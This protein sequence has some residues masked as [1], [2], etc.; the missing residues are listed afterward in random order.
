L[1]PETE[2]RLRD[3]AAQSGQSWKAFLLALIEREAG[4]A[5]GTTPA[6]SPTFE[7]M[8]APLAQAVEAE[9]VSEEELGDFFKGVLKKVRAERRPRQDDSP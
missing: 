6:A 1:P 5:N 2:R 4:T 7:E 8:T 3:K 9:G